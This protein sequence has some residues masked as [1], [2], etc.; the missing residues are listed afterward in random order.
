MRAL[1]LIGFLAA[2]CGSEA[3][4]EG[5]SQDA[6]AA[7]DLSLGACPATMPGL[8]TACA[9]NGLS[10]HYAD[11]ICDCDYGFFYCRPSSCPPRTSVKTGLACGAGDHM[12]IYGFEFGCDCV[13]PDD[14]WLCCGG[15][16]APN[17]AV[18]DGELCCGF[19]TFMTP[20]ADGV[21]GTC[22]CD[23]SHHYH[24]TGYSCSDGG[25]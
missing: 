9:T 19:E 13:T 18:Q 2:G 22:T 17:G 21:A 5:M 25:I 11:Q 7:D 14:V 10:C 24:C 6:S 4:E 15:T 12:C 8:S 20:C 1:L 3:L 16:I 23:A